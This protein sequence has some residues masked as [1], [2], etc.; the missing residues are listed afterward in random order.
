MTCAVGV[1]GMLP[2]GVCGTSVYMLGIS[3]Q[4]D[5]TSCETPSKRLRGVS[6]G[7]RPHQYI[8]CNQ[9]GT[10]GLMDTSPPP[11]LKLSPPGCALSL[12]EICV[13]DLPEGQSGAICR[14]TSGRRGGGWGGG[15]KLEGAGGEEEECME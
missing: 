15:E 5:M 1:R 12:S 11:S 2:V 10:S 7:T 4:C 3:S 13:R 14:W 6:A 9:T 8:I